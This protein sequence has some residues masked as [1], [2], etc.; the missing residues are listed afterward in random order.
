MLEQLLQQLERKAGSATQITVQ[1]VRLRDWHASLFRDHE[2]DEKVVYLTAAADT[3]T[4]AVSGLLA[5]PRVATG[6]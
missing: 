2:D 4:D 1:R 3:P 6:L 5:D